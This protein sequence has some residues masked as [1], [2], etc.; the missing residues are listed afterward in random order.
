MLLGVSIKTCSSGPVL[1][2]DVSVLKKT[3]KYDCLA[4]KNWSSG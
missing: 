2:I 1:Y 3:A 4:V